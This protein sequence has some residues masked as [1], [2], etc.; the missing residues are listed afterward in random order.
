MRARRLLGALDEPEFRRLYLARAFSQLG[1]GLVPVALAFAVLEVD[2]SP[3]ALGFVLAARSIPMA[4][5]R[6]PQ[7]HGHAFAVLGPALAGVMI[8]V[9]EPGWANA[10]DSAT[11]LI[12]AGFLAGLRLPRALERV[13]LGFL[14]ELRPRR[15]RPSPRRSA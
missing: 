15:G 13:Q 5:E 9:S 10:V 11:F 3:S 4:G 1:D 7:R 12:S 2:A 6:A 14:T 8:A